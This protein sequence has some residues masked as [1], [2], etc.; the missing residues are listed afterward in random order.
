V[1]SAILGL[2]PLPA[3]R[4]PI[5]P[6]EVSEMLTGDIA[7]YQIQDRIREAEQDRASR[8]PRPGRAG[9]RAAVV[10]RVGSG[11]FGAAFGRR[12]KTTPTSSRLG[13]PLV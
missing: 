2:H 3:Y 13:I 11:L 9:G 5:E 6:R 7:K 8:S 1:V 12:R 4:R 10:R